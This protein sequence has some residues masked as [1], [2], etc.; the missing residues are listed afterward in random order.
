MHTSTFGSEGVWIADEPRPTHLR[1][2]RT[3]LALGGTL[4]ICRGSCVARRLRSRSARARFARHR[5]SAPL[6]VSQRVSQPLLLVR[7]GARRTFCS[8]SS[9]QALRSRCCTQALGSIVAPSRAYGW[10][11]VHLVS[12]PRGP[13][14]GPRG[15][16]N[17]PC[18]PQWASWPTEWAS[19]PTMCL[20]AH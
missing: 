16:M 13:L 6:A 11:L 5:R 10:S 18:G 8:R 15:P 14:K 20:V 19:R 1:S 4:V 7:S 3:L 12:T 9:T 2:T 17:G